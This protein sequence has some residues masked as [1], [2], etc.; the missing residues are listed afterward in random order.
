M[1]KTSPTKIR[2]LAIER[3]LAGGRKMK[4]K[5]IQRELERKYE[6]YANK[7]AIFDDIA[8]LNMFIPIESTR[9]PAGGFQRVDVLARCKD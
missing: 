2:I 5:E 1:A 6:I 8:A 7:E 4:V 3:M 9:G